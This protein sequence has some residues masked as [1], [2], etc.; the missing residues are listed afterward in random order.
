[1]S[2]LEAL[3]DAVIV[4][5][6]EIEE[7]QYGSIIVPDMGKDRNVHGTVVAVGPGTYTVTGEFI[8][9]QIKEG[10]QVVLPTMG[11]TK[12]EHEGVEYFIGNEKQVLAKVIEDEKA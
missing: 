2:K 7:T 6:T 10:D 8:K 3:F 12:V 4:K 11:F 9:T 5:P 1:M